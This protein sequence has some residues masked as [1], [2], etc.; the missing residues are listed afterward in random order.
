MPVLAE[1]RRF[2]SR[3]HAALITTF[4]GA[5]ALLATGCSS[6]PS[7]TSGAD[8]EASGHEAGGTTAATGDASTSGGDD[9]SATSGA[10]DGAATE[11]TGATSAEAGGDTAAPSTPVCFFSDANYA[12]KSFCVGAGSADLPSDW[13]DVISSVKVASGYRVD[14]Y[15][16]IGAGGR[17]LSLIADEPNLPICFFND[18]ASS[19]RV[20]NDTPSRFQSVNFL[21]KISGCHI[22]AGQHNDEKGDSPHYYTDIVHSITGQYPALWSGDF[23]FSGDSTA[24]WALTHE[25][26]AEWKRGAIV[27]F[28]FHACPPTT[29][30]SCGWDPGIIGKLTDDQ[31]NDLI[32]DGGGLNGAWKS[33]LDELVPY[34]TELAAQGVE[35]LFRPHHEMN[36]GVFWWAGRTGPNG[37]ARL[38]QITHD[39]LVKTKGFTNIAFVWDV[40]DLSTNYADYDPGAD[41]YDLGAIDYYNG[42]SSDSDYGDTKYH[43]AMAPVVGDKPM[44]IGE[45]FYLP[46]PAAQSRLPYESF[47]MIWAYG[48]QKDLNGNPTNSNDAIVAAYSDPRVVRL[49]DMPGWK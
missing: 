32:T 15:A 25:A 46:D 28:M 8:A 27:Q 44:A 13:N 4:V 41:Y 22:A 18:T 37:T 1:R 16:D 6:T 14:L 10:S 38:F 21:R 7:A 17:K 47:F 43:D 12:G 36:Q 26:E 35:V 24:R 33:R 3:L 30:S 42:S 2:A 23:G 5:G 40:Q 49:A 34:F 9:A 20:G 48:L 31:W 39:Y 19:Y 45:T 29:G 11:T